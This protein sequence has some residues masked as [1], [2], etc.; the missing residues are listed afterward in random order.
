MESEQPKNAQL[1]RWFDLSYVRS[2]VLAGGR[3]A[4]CVSLFTHFRTQISHPFFAN[5]PVAVCVLHFADYS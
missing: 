4:L 1:R 5:Y 3:F 2:D